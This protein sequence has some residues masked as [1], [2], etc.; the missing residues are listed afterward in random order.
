MN[1][2]K[3]IFSIDALFGRHILL[4]FLL[5]P[6][7]AAFFLPFLPHLSMLALFQVWKEDL[8]VLVR[9]FSCSLNMFWFSKWSSLLVSTWVSIFPHL[10]GQFSWD[11]S[12]A[13]SD[14]TSPLG[15]WHWHRWSVYVCSLSH[16]QSYCWHCTG[17][18]R[19]ASPSIHPYFRCSL[20]PRIQVSFDDEI[21][22]PQHVPNPIPSK[23]VCIIVLLVPFCSFFGLI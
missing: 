22:L 13:V 23:S 19:C 3:G 4:L 12:P 17:S 10:Q 14:I 16:D 18:R 5:P 7:R 1:S 2:S 15:S 6:C 21:S 9:V 11:W 20:D 8:W